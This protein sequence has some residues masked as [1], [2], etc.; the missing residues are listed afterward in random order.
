[1]TAWSLRPIGESLETLEKAP[2]TLKKARS[3]TGGGTNPEMC[4][5]GDALK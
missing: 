4:W 5:K 1:M 3:K 2:G